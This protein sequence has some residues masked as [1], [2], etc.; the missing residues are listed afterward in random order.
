MTLPPS[1]ATRSSAAATSLTAKYGSEKVSPG[2]EPRSWMSNSG[3]SERVCP[4]RPSPSRRASSSTPR[5]STQKRRARPGSSAGNSRRENGG[6]PI[7]LDDSGA[8]APEGRD[9]LSS[10]HEAP[11]EHERAH[12]SRPPAGSGRA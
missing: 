9:R 12:H 7:E 1:S 5:N 11:G 6:V 10:H 4:P 8:P 2:P 3:P